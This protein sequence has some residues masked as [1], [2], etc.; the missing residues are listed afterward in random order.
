MGETFIKRIKVNRLRKLEGLNIAISE[1]KRKHLIITG[2]NGSGKTTLLREI[3]RYLS[4][5][6]NKDTFPEYLQIK[7]S[8]AELRTT[9]KLSET[10]FSKFSKY[11]SID[12]DFSGEENLRKEFEEGALFFAFLPAH[13]D[14]NVKQ[15]MSIEKFQHPNV[16][17]TLNVSD[18]FLK[19]LVYLRSLLTDA[20]YS[21]KTGEA[22][23]LEL[24]FKRFEYILREIFADQKLRLEYDS[25]NITFYLLE[26]GQDRTDFNALSD[27]YAA[28]IRIITELIMRIEGK[29]F[30]A[31]DVQGIALIDEIETHLHIELQRSVLPFLTTF[32]PRIQ[33]IVTTHSP[34]IL[35]SIE[36][37]VV[38][39]LE[40]KIR[41]EEPSEISS[42]ALVKNYFMV[43]SDYSESI[44]NKVFEF[45]K[46]TEASTLTEK[47]ESRLADLLMDLS[48]LSPTLSPEIYLRF[49]AAEEKIK[50]KQA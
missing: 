22:N 15:A 35:N 40:N 31:H 12:I 19:Y 8:E 3:G 14:F 18:Y 2:K 43:D 4:G 6:K 50:E 13:R 34:F 42:L 47:E 5:E 26:N 39:D 27:G 45:E 29:G 48:T 36:N 41:I 30:R 44:E 49:K 17:L 37:A 46:L 9:F 33:F 32:F 16:D 38:Y 23:R 10:E 1:A 20:Y 7:H 11:Q 21:K 24:W 28:V 25:Q